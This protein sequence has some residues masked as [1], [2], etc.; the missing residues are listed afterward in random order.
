MNNIKGNVMNKNAYRKRMSSIVDYVADTVGKT[1]GPCGHT[2]LIQTQ[3]SVIS[4]KDG[5]NL[6]QAIKFDNLIDNSMKSMIESCGQSVVLRVGDG[7]TSVV[8]AASVLNQELMKIEEKYNY[9]IRDIES[10]LKT[11]VNDIV[12]KLRENAIPISEDNL[13]EGIYNVAMVST[14]WNEELS[15]IIADIYDKTHNPIIKVLESG[16][17]ETYVD[18]INGYDLNGSLLLSNFYMT[19]LERQL[20]ELHNPRI[21]M[22]ETKVPEKYYAPLS[23]IAGILATKG[24]Y[25]V[26]L[27]PDFDMTFIRHIKNFNAIASKTGKNYMNLIPATYISNYNIDKEC[28]E[29]FA[30]LTGTT[31][32]GRNDEELIEFFD[33]ITTNMTTK[34]IPTEGLT[35][36]E[37][38]SAIASNEERNNMRNAI[39]QFLPAKLDEICGSCD[40]ITISNKNITVDG[41]THQNT[42][43]VDDRRKTLES[44][45]NGKIKECDALTMLTDDIRQKRIRLGKLQ[46]SMGIIKIG[47]YGKTNLKAIKDALDD[48][49]RACEAAYRDGYT[50]GS[51]VAI[52]IAIKSILDEHIDDEDFYISLKHLILDAIKYSFTRVFRQL[53]INKD[54][55]FDTDDVETCPTI[56]VDGDGLTID[57]ILTK[58]VKSKCGFDILTNTFD[59]GCTKIINPVNVDIE[60]LLGCMRLVINCFSSDQFVFTNFDQVIDLDLDETNENVQTVSLMSRAKKST[61]GV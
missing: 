16:T 3:D 14:N 38:E 30:A 52:G 19:D 1:F 20:C 37:L 58:C 43:M 46:G 12:S 39:L 40:T 45:I 51:S 25:L 44:E 48:A 23:L 47:G 10:G 27:A 33:D 24:E 7:S 49:T 53:F 35:G 13:R 42:K 57:H 34:E 61:Y 5:W 56:K 11:C 36:D 18:I 9:T 4:T 17:T 2:A 22:F 8:L 41:L 21:M 50:V 26:V 60:I 29:D 59:T 54:G 28:V 31:I 32:I 55:S 15:N 6:T